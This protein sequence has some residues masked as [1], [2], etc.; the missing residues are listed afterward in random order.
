M[1]HTQSDNTAAADTPAD[2]PADTPA[3][4]GTDPDTTTD[5]G[6]WV[7]TGGWP[8]DSVVLIGHPAAPPAPMHTPAGMGGLIVS[9][10][11]RPVDDDERV[12]EFIARWVP[13]PIGTDPVPQREIAVRIAVIEESDRAAQ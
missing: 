6:A 1:Q 7:E 10:V 3:R 11:E 2:I 13:D 8:G 4:P 12:V 9:G 5:L